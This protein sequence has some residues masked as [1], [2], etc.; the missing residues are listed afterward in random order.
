MNYHISNY[1]HVP[2]YASMIKT[3]AEKGNYKWYLT[4]RWIMS[5]NRPVLPPLA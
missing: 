2:R 3:Q 5:A 1:L 4:I